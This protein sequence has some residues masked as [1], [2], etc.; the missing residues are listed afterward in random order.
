M[1]TTTSIVP[2][3]LRSATALTRCRANVGYS[4]KSSANVVCSQPD[5]LGDT[6]DDADGAAPSRT[7]RRAGAAG[8]GL[9]VLGD[10]QHLVGAVAVEV[11][12]HQLL[13]DDRHVLE[14][15]GSELVLDDGEV[16]R[17]RQ[18]HGRRRSGHDVPVGPYGDAELRGNA[19]SVAEGHVVGDGVLATARAAELLGDRLAG[20]ERLGRAVEPDGRERITGLVGQRRRR[21]PEGP[22][23]G[24][25][26]PAQRRRCG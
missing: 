26:P 19:G 1:S 15:R 23:P 4:S 5:R 8:V 7:S 6:V 16:L 2:S 12:A 22:P 10:D 11:D 9:R 18:V 24:A 13:E 17:R 14:V 21:K 3:P 20:D 25:L